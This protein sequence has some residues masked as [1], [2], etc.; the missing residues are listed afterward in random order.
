M[1]IRLDIFLIIF[2]AALVTFIPRVLPMM[3][4]SRITI[5]EWG[6]RW[7]SYVPI[8][9]MSAL[10]AQELFIEEGKFTSLSSNVELIAALPTFWVAIKTRSLL[11][12][13]LTG[14]LS[15]MLLRLLM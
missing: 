8:A 2:G 13:V 14:V 11:G 15:L 10:V 6:M 12:T 9:I 5:P 3:L 7:L 4:L 1:E